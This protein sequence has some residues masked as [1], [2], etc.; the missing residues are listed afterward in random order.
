MTETVHLLTMHCILWMAV[1]SKITY[2]PCEE[3]EKQ[4][5]F[6]DAKFKVKYSECV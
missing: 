4:P 3:N 5:G 2:N 1:V 6:L